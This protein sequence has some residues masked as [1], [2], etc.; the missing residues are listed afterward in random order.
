M[1]T[2]ISVAQE[3]GQMLAGGALLFQRLSAQNQSI[4]KI[5]KEASNTQ[6]RSSLRSSNDDQICYEKQEWSIAALGLL[7][8]CRQGSA[9]NQ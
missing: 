4:G 1:R 9:G 5:T 8:G 3:M 6:G 7:I 2:A